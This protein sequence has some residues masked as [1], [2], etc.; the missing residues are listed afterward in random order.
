MGG[1]KT[2]EESPVENF[3]PTSRA[4]KGSTSTME[5]TATIYEEVMDEEQVCSCWFAEIREIGGKKQVGAVVFGSGFGS[6]TQNI[7][8]PIESL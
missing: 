4:E 1:E 6:Y 2:N 8:S 7:K 5:I 3:H